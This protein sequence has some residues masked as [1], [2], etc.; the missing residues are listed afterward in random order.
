M[1]QQSDD[2][3]L[4]V[5]ALSRQ[6]VLLRALGKD[7]QA[8]AVIAQALREAQ[9]LTQSG[10]WRNLIVAQINTA[11]T[12]D[13]YRASL[14]LAQGFDASQALERRGEEINWLS[15]LAMV[16]NALGDYP[17]ALRLYRQALDIG[18][19]IKSPYWQAFSISNI[20]ATYHYMG[21]VAEA[22][23]LLQ[24]G[25]ALGEF[26]NGLRYHLACAHQALGQRVEAVQEAHAVL[27]MPL[28]LRLRLRTTALLLE[29]Y[30]KLGN[31]AAR[32]ETQAQLLQLVEGSDHPELRAIGMAALLHYGDLQAKRKAKAW[33][34]TISLEQLPM[35][36]YQLFSTERPAPK[37]ER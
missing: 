35:P 11:Q 20:A 30:Y 5:D 37:V 16:H 21:R 10:V 12:R 26:S 31:Q 3:A 9:G 22:L 19:S 36:T 6:A 27:A 4:R 17:Q 28:T 8:K 7:Q 14:S 15:S 25:L 13:E 1:I 18:Q 34:Q 24:E 2:Q 33:L 23:Q 32:Q 29:L